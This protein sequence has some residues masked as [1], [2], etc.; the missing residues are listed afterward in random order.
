MHPK[1]RKTQFV[2]LG[3][4]PGL[5]E[6]ITA[7]RTSRYKG[8]TLKRDTEF[9]VRQAARSLGKWSPKGPVF[10]VYRWFEPDRRRDKDNISSFGRKVIQDALVHGG[11]LPNDVRKTIDGFRDLFFVDEKRPRV[12]VEIWEALPCFQ[13]TKVGPPRLGGFS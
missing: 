7:E 12:E 9:L 8:A 10:M 5:N 3:R 13:S 6:Y 4:L 1:K 2:I 11:W